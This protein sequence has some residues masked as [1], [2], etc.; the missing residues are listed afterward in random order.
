MF[1]L[2]VCLF[3]CCGG[4]EVVNR[5]VGGFTMLVTKNGKREGVCVWGWSLE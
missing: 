2:F 5:V 3:V 4:A 1:C